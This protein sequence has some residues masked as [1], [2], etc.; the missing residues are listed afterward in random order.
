MPVRLILI[1]ILVVFEGA[2]IGFNLNNKCDVWLVF[3]VFESVPVYITILV[4]FIAGV[5]VSIPFFVFKKK[6]KLPAKTRKERSGAEPVI[7]EDKAGFSSV[8]GKPAENSSSA[9]DKTV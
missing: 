8:S 6:K 5:L 3:R 4:S 1:L 9:S 2:F 7:K